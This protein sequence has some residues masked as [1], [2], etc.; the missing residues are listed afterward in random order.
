MQSNLS[1]ISTEKLLG[2]QGCFLF[3]TAVNS[4]HVVLKI[5]AISYISKLQV[6]SSDLPRYY[7]PHIS[8]YELFSSAQAIFLAADIKLTFMCDTPSPLHTIISINRATLVSK[9]TVGHTIM[10]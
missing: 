2:G 5:T 8:A 6:F 4:V 7:L 1:S 10:K 3:H 9:M